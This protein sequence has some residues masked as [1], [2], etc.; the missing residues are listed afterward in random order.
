MGRVIVNSDEIH[1]NI[2]IPKE[3]RFLTVVELYNTI[4]FK[5]EL[6]IIFMNKL[7]KIMS[8]LIIVN[9][10][11]CSKTLVLSSVVRGDRKSPPAVR[12]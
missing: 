12:R 5:N 6:A 8:G 3:I 1:K 11:N 4:I 10:N 7:C 2:K 9:K